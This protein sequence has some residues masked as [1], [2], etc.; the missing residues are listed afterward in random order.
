MTHRAICEVLRGFGASVVSL[1]AV[2]NG[3]PDIAIAYRGRTYLCEIKNGDR[4]WTMT[5]QQVRFHA[6][7]KDQILVMDSVEMAIGW[8]EAVSRHG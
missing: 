6:E 2:G 8:V 7:W 5:P 3:C 4:K 1:A